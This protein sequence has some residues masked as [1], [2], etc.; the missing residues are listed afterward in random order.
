MKRL[1][2]RITL[3]ALLVA[4]AGC[5]YQQSGAPVNESSGYHWKSL[6]REDISTVA[7]P[8]FG[9]RTYRRNLE[10]KLTKAIIDQLEADSPYK[11]VSRERADTVLEGEVIAVE[12]KT[13]S[14][15][16]SAVPQEQLLTIIVNFSW[17]DQRT[18]RILVERRG[19]EQSAPYYPTLGEGQ[20][21]GAQQ[22]IEQLARG[23][24]EEMQ[25]DW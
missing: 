20:F 12:I 17:K 6:Y 24:I 1:I 10:F 18:G 25:A 21:V 15:S 13:I 8:I 22:N 3:T 9:N 2:Q 14:N 23:I 11:V 19:F 4:P 7:V 5:G 16:Q